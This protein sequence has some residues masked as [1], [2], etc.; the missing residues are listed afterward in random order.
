MPWNSI[1][2]SVLEN[3]VF[4]TYKHLHFTEDLQ[5]TIFSL[6]ALSDFELNWY[7]FY[8]QFLGSVF[9]FCKIKGF[10]PGNIYLLWYNS[11]NSLNYVQN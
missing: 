8:L 9:Y 6:E 2:D 4:G 11:G 3:R 1:A 5:F 10:Y 7:A